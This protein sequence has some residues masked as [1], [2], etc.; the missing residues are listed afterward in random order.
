MTEYLPPGTKGEGVLCVL[1]TKISEVEN[2]FPRKAT[3]SAPAL[4]SPGPAGAAASSQQPAFAGH[5][6][7][8]PKMCGSHLGD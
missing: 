1:M 6:C 7:T 4:W 5:V 3:G 2:G 8:V